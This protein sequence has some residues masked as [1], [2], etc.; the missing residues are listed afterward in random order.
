MRPALLAVLL[1]LALAGCG[2]QHWQPWSAQAVVMQGIGTGLH[3]VDWGTTRDMV[4]RGYPDRMYEQNPIL[5]KHP[6]MGE[7]DVY[8]VLTIM[9]AVVLTD[10]LPPSW[11]P[12]WLGGYIAVEGY[13]AH[14]NLSADGPG[15]R[16]ALRIRF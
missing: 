12:W 9:G 5:G 11:R 8:N 2:G 10:Y 7:V 4:G 16:G 14:N 1:A 3:V 13:C 6:T 15:G